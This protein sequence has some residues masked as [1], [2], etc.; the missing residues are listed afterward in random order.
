MIHF[1]FI[2]QQVEDMPETQWKGYIEAYSEDPLTLTLRN[3]ED[4]YHDKEITYDVLKT[5]GYNG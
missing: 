2:L 4:E 3:E 1:L 5:V